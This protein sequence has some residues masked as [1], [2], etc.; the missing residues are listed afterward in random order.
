M[1]GN[2]DEW[3]ADGPR[4]YR[5]QPETDPVGPT[6]DG[7]RVVRGGGWYSDARDVRC[8]LR[9]RYPA[10]NEGDYLSFRLVRVQERS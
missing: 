5:D 9:F 8:A 2:V 4:D 7:S 1:L 3:C 10:D 6:G